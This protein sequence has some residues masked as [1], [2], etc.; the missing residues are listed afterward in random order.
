MDLLTPE[1]NCGM[2]SYSRKERSVGSKVRSYDGIRREKIE[3]ARM[4]KMPEI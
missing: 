3:G 4:K 2:Q 1:M